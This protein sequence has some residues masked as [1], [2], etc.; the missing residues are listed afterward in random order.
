M[1]RIT[2]EINNIKLNIKQLEKVIDR[3]EKNID[4]LSKKYWDLNI[5]YCFLQKQNEELEKKKSNIEMLPHKY[6]HAL[7]KTILNLLISVIF[8]IVMMYCALNTLLLPFFVS[9]LIDFAFFAVS[10]KEL[11]ECIDIKQ[12]YNN[13]NN[14]L[15][16]IKE[17]IDENNKKHEKYVDKKNKNEIAK[18]LGNL[19]IENRVF[20]LSRR[21]L[22]NKVLELQKLREQIINLCNLDNKTVEEKINNSTD[23]ELKDE[24]SKMKK[25]GTIKKKSSNSEE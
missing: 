9:I 10:F 17:Q 3:N 21:E 4:K 8:L 18:Q 11:N 13:M 19:K 5:N 25:K 12:K 23:E 24:I 2:N 16:K 6:K 15:E 20:S 1:D 22:L 14:D 7:L